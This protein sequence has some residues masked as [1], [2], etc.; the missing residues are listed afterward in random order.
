MQEL[1]G[2]T[3]R[4]SAVSIVV[5]IFILNII[6]AIINWV[7]MVYQLGVLG[8]P[9][10]LGALRVALQTNQGPILLAQIVIETALIA[11]IVVA[12]IGLYRLQRW[13]WTLAM[14]ILGIGLAFNLL[15][16]LRGDPAYVL[17]LVR[18]I[19]VILLDQEPV[20][21]AFGQKVAEHV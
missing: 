20:R 7:L 19:A 8:V 21:F 12:T 18:V 4:P 11:I 13:A 15:N 10:P 1:T 9:D 2:P 3:S 14:L 16:Y 6:S 5:L 17:M